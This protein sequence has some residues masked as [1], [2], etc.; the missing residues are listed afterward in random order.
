M[1]WESRNGRNKT[2]ADQPTSQLDVTGAY[3][4]GEKAVVTDADQSR[5]QHVQQKAA[6]ELVDVESEELFAIAMCIVAIAE[7]D[8]LPVER[9]DPGVADGDAVGVVGEISENLLRLGRRAEAG[10]CQL[11]PRVS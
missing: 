6:E 1:A 10:P 3:A 5:R 2:S 9:D 7:R 11:L 4:V 8:T